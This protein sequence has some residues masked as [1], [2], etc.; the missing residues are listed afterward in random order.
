MTNPYYD[1]V[2]LDESTATATLSTVNKS[3][4]DEEAG[5]END[6]VSGTYAYSFKETAAKSAATGLVTVTQSLGNNGKLTIY[7]DAPG[8]VTVNKEWSTPGSETDSVT[9]RIYAS[10]KVKAVGESASVSGVWCLGEKTISANDK[11]DENWKTVF[12]NLPDEETIG[13]YTYTYE[14]FYI[15]ELQVGEDEQ[16][17]TSYKD[18][19][20]E[21]IDTTKLTLTAKDNVDSAFLKKYPMPDSDTTVDV[22]IA[23]GGEVTVV[24]SSTYTLPYTGGEGAEPYYITGVMLIM[25]SGAILSAR[26]LRRHY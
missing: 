21:A 26:K 8:K 6:N 11:A 17:I 3:V 22:A 24:N 23:N 4:E 12:T 5:T 19:D 10:G 7:R 18:A 13:N 1:S 16:Y 15:R 25:L 2:S 9:V 20:G 14:N